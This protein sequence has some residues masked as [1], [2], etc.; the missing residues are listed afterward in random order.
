MT[1][2]GSVDISR[3]KMNPQKNAIYECYIL[4]GKF[5]EKELLEVTYG[6]CRI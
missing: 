3:N 6:D 4:I 1:K 2:T 5:A